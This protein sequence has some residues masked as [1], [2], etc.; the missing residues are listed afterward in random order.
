MIDAINCGTTLYLSLIYY[1]DLL[2]HMP[3]FIITDTISLRNK[4]IIFDGDGF[5]K[6]NRSKSL[7]IDYIHRIFVY[8]VRN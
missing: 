1:F 8:R 6:I 7:N 4:L 3:I 5:Y 2:T